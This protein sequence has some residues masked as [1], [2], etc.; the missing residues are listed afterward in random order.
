MAP[1][2]GR[3][4]PRRPRP[5]LVLRPQ[6]RT[7]YGR[8]GHAVHRP[9]EAIFNA[10]PDVFRSAL[11]GIGPEARQRPVIVIEPQPDK[12]PATVDATARFTEEL[13]PTGRRP[14]R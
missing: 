5:A 7:G 10:H 12:F 14:I 1:H 3:R 2:G 8:R 9:C 11:V 6:G 4:L 13:L